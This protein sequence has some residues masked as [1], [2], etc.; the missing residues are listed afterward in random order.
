MGFMAFRKGR[1]ALSGF[2]I[3]FLV[4]YLIWKASLVTMQLWWLNPE[5]GDQG[6]PIPISER[7]QGRQRSRGVKK[8]AQKSPCQGGSRGCLP[9]VRPWGNTSAVL[10]LPHLSNRH[11]RAPASKDGCEGQRSPQTV[12]RPDVLTTAWPLLSPGENG[13]GR[14]PG[15]L[16]NQVG[17]IRGDRERGCHGGCTQMAT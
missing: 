13:K 11:G 6:G 10:P 15:R 1:K 5:Q 8:K 16:D 4:I 9:D 7:T 2:H 14:W 17:G 12:P 3:S